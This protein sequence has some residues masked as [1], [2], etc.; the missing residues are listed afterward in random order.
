[1]SGE[2]VPETSRPAVVT[3]GVRDVVAAVAAPRP[4]DAPGGVR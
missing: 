2:A 4:T 1:M 3:A